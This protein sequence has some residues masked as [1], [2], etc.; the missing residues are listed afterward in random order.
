MEM[1]SLS[2]YEHGAKEEETSL[3]DVTPTGANDAVLEEQF[4]SVH[5][6]D[7]V[8][9]PLPEGG[10]EVSVHASLLPRPFT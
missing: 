1:D 5:F 7:S 10:S 3:I 4:P 9:S 2:T 8:N 6:E